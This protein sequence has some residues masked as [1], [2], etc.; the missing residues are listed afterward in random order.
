[1]KDRAERWTRRRELMV[2]QARLAGATEVQAQA[3]VPRVDVYTIDVGFDAIPDP[4]ERDY[5][6]NQPTSFVLPA[7]AIDRLREVAGRLLRQ[8]KEYESFVHDL[9][10]TPAK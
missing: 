10:G 3:S 6:M 9:G 4:K 8:S 7:E 5:F 1:M 2:A